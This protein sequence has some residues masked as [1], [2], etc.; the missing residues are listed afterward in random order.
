MFI[1]VTRGLFDKQSIDLVAMKVAAT[2]GD[3]RMLLQLS[4][5]C[6]VDTMAHFQREHILLAPVPGSIHSGVSE[7]NPIARLDEPLK[8]GEPIVPII[9]TRHMAQVIRDTGNGPLRETNTVARLS[10]G[11]RTLLVAMFCYSTA[12]SAP[13]MLHHRTENPLLGQVAMT[14][15][16]MRQAF[17]NYKTIKAGSIGHDPTEENMRRW[18]EELHCSALI[19]GTWAISSFHLHLLYSIEFY[20]KHNFILFD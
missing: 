19:E 14:C 15:T 4:D 11:A 10:D 20:T 9:Y 17:I 3:V 7:H 5:R 18:T 13:S 2:T 6:L 16:Q 12:S 1:Y 8:P